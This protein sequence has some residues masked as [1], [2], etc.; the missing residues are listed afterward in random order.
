MYDEMYNSIM[1]TSSAE[2][3][4]E[5]LMTLEEFLMERSREK[6]SLRYLSKFCKTGIDQFRDSEFTL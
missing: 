2:T 5:F 6:A 3:L 4:Q 1:P